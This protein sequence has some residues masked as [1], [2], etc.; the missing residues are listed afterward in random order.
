MI[1]SRATEAKAMLGRRLGVEFRV[2]SMLRQHLQ[3]M[4]FILHMNVDSLKKPEKLENKP[5]PF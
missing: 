5:K 2:N 4:L 1:K 3:H